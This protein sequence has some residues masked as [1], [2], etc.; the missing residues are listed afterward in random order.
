MRRARSQ[1]EPTALLTVDGRP[2]AFSM[3]AFTL[4][5]TEVTDPDVVS[6]QE[7]A[8]LLAKT[9][10]RR[11]GVF[12]DSLSLGV[13]DASPGYDALGWPARVERVLRRVHPDLEYLNT[14]RLGATTPQALDEQAQRIE[15][16]QPDLL[17]LNSGANDI[18]RRRVDW[19]QVEDGLR[20][21]YEWASCTGAQLSVLTLGRSFV[22]ATVP[23]FPERVDRLNAITR[24]LAAEFGAVVGECW[25]HR[26]N[27]RP[28]LV[29]EDRIHFAS[30]GQ[31]VVASVMI[32]A[33]GRWTNRLG[34]VPEDVR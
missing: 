21:M 13:G 20:S 14:A 24:A 19:D 12:G 23:D 16:F 34:Q 6:P 15:D 29:S 8:A 33:L 28:H 22:M 9:P 31:A 30:M 4:P 3:T 11:Y 5:W 2:Y 25:D 32:E 27:D 10:W 7:G 26:L 18:I 1:L 17:H